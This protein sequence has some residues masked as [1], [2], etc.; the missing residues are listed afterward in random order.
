MDRKKSGYGNF[1]G[2]G[3]DLTC[4]EA[5]AFINL[6]IHLKKF[7]F[8]KYHLSAVQKKLKTRNSWIISWHSLK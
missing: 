8:K 2:N 5:F 4:Y 6:E 1:E 3:G 7:G